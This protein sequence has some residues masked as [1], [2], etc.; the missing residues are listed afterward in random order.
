[1]NI[2]ARDGGMD[3]VDGDDGETGSVSKKKGKQK[4]TTGISACLTLDF[5]DKEESNNNKSHLNRILK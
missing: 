1:M 5:R 3:I 2:R 4:F